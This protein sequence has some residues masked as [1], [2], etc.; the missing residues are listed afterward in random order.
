MYLKKKKTGARHVHIPQK[1]QAHRGGW[2]GD[3]ASHQG[4][5]RV[6]PA[7]GGGGDRAAAGAGGGWAVKW[8][9]RGGGVK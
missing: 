6:G 3:G 2:A 4:K 9:R 1:P 5:N 8:V 7:G